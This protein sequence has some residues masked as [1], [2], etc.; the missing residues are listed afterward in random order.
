MNRSINNIPSKLFSRLFFASLA[1]PGHPCPHGINA[2]LHVA[3]CENHIFSG[4][5]G[6]EALMLQYGCLG[7]F[8][9]CFGD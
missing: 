6:L 5:S 9:F 8:I 1:V 7:N 4:S 3:L 2:S